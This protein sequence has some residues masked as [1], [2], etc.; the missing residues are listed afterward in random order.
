VSQVRI[1]LVDD[2]T[3]FRQGL[4]MLLEAQEE[5]QVVA[6]ASGGEEALRKARE[7]H[8]DVVLMDIAMP[9]M[10]GIE[11]TRRLREEVPQVKV[12]VITVHGGDDY[13]F[14]A[15]EAG[16][17]G[18]I[19]KEAAF[20]DVIAAVRG[21]SQGGVFL[22]PSLA[23]KLVSDY[24]QRLSTGDER[25]SYER[26]TRR[27]RQVLALIAEGHTNQQI[28]D[29]LTL[30]V[31]TIQTHRSHIMEKLGLQSRAELM[32]FAVRAGFL[33]REP[34]HHPPQERGQTD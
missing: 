24:L 18:Y 32:R 10:N 29:Y 12:L 3:L 17:S 11:A 6:E 23:G 19:L 14:H 1:M 2:H 9:D 4:R 26:L 21:V 5:F 25:T 28:A 22:Y 8:P 13:F 30:S 31:N 27:E 16:T 33:S 15:L 20:A 34:G 7:C